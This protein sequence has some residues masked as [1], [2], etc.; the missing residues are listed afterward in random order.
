M[1][2]HLY[3]SLVPEAFIASM[4]DPEAFGAYYACGTMKK[5][6]GQAMFVEVDPAFRSRDFRIAE[7]LERCKPHEDG[8]PKSSVYIAVY[9]VAERIPVSALGA[10]HLT[11]SDGRV[12]ALEKREA[13]EDVDEGLRLYQELSP[14]RP[15]VASTK[16]PMAFYRHMTDASANLFALPALHFADLRLDSLATDPESG[17]C[18]DLPYA[19]MD[20][21]RQCLVDIRTKPNGIKMV[22]RNHPVV[23]PYRTVRTG[24]YFGRGQELAFF[25]MP[26]REDLL[27][28]YYNWWR[29]AQ[30]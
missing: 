28:K 16:P 14:T 21:L 10:L 6:H 5:A 8:R 2:T 1:S 26:S 22:D 4:L 9:R 23:F 11:T 17:G 19:N 30:M 29:S 7:A 15:L 20:H 12:L 3:L 25:P 18:D 13:P 27:G 24:F